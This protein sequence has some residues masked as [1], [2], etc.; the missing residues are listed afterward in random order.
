MSERVA[1][2]IQQPWAWAI[3]AGG[4]DIENR[5]WGHCYRGPIL[6]HAA[7]KY[8]IW[9]TDTVQKM[10]PSFPGRENLQFG[11]IIGEAEIIDCV[12]DH[13]SPWFGGRFGFVLRNQ[14]QLPFFA[15]RGQLGL[16]KVDL[17]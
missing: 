15:C 7:K 8:D 9:G 11:G 1:L 5:S 6:I 2:S 16:F 13:D 12:T 17:P 14:R 4:K 10:C 3:V